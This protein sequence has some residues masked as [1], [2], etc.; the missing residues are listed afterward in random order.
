MKKQKK[1][2]LALHKKA[3]SNL[4]NFIVGGRSNTTGQN[5]QALTDL[6]ACQ[7]DCPGDI[8]NPTNRGCQS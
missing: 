7:R 5:A 8:P 6:T 1:Q 2:Q 4:D 3:I